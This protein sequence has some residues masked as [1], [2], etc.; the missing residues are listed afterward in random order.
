MQSL[1]QCAKLRLVFD[2][3]RSASDRDPYEDDEGPYGEE[4][5]PSYGRDP[6]A[7]RGYT[8]P[9]RDQGFLRP[10]RSIEPI[11]G[12]TRRDADELA[13]RASSDT[14]R[15]LGERRAAPS[16]ERHPVVTLLEIVGGA[17]G[18]AWLTERFR[19]TSGSKLPTGAVLGGIGLGV[20]YSNIVGHRTDLR[21]VAFGAL[22]A[23]VV[24]YALGKGALASEKA[25]AEVDGDI[26]APPVAP[27]PPPIRNLETGVVRTAGAATR[28]DI[29]A[30]LR[31]RRSTN[32]P[33]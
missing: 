10:V 19:E 28:E 1:L 16:A 29:A 20:A 25:Q 31:A 11:M 17:F 33:R 9:R 7:S 27:P 18:S 24:V 15:F 13:S 5:S 4:E 6:Y 23:P 12:M 14:D 2:P 3:Y 22:V 8:R 21:N 30:I 26:A 32:E